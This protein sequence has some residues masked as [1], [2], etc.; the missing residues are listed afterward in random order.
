M[1]TWRHS[2]FPGVPIGIFALLNSVD[3]SV[4]IEANDHAAMATIDGNLHSGS[5]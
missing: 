5:H 1:R 2:G 3:N 4:H